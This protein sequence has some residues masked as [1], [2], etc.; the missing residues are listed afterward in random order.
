[1]PGEHVLWRDVADGTVKTGVVVMREI[2]PQQSRRLI[3]F[4][5]AEESASNQE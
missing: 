5:G 3:A 2:L 4:D 1:M